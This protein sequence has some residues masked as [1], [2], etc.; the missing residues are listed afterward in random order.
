MQSVSVLC[1]YDASFKML[2]GILVKKGFEIKYAD[3][4]EGIIK[5]HVKKKLLRREKSIDVIL[6][7]L[8]HNTTN[9]KLMI[10]HN[11][12][13]FDKPVTADELEE[14]KLVDSIYKHF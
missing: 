12:D 4:K 1:P 7:K 8:D 3:K 9:I 6:Y 13:V 14:R 11:E 5:G 2:Q 10:N